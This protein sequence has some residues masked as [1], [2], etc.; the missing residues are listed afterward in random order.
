MCAAWCS[1]HNIHHR[2]SY[3]WNVLPAPSPVPSQWQLQPA[4]APVITYDQS[5]HPSS[6]TVNWLP[7][8]LQNVPLTPASMP[9][10]PIP[11]PTSSLSLPSSVIPHQSPPPRAPQMPTYSPAPNNQPIAGPSRVAPSP[12]MVPLLP[13]RMSSNAALT[14]MRVADPRPRHLSGSPRERELANI[15]FMQEHARIQQRMVFPPPRNSSYHREAQT[16]QQQQQQ[17]HRQGSSS[18]DF[19][20]W[21]GHEL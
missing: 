14:Q 3:S 10:V 15:R 12:Q 11:I 18:G 8:P 5:M 20:G 21:A 9:L 19:Q 1:P 6:S 17:Q 2:S 4:Q 13:M 7:A 16:Q